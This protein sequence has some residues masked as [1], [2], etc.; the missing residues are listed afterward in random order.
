MKYV[1]C[2][3]R[4]ALPRIRIIVPNK[5]PSEWVNACVSLQYKQYSLYILEKSLEKLLV[6]HDK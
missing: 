6:Q 1:G 4:E 2:S 3:E 5:V